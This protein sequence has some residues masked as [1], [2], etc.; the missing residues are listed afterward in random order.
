MYI[1]NGRFY[2]EEPNILKYSKKIVVSESD[3]MLSFYKKETLNKEIIYTFSINYHN[4]PVSPDDF[5]F[6]KLLDKK[7]MERN[8]NAAIKKDKYFKIK[9]LKAKEVVISF[10]IEKWVSDAIKPLRISR[11]QG[12][13]TYYI[14]SNN[15]LPDLV[16]E[17]IDPLDVLKINAIL[18]SKL[19]SSDYY[20]KRFRGSFP[21]ELIFKEHKTLKFINIDYDVYNNRF[22]INIRNDIFQ[23]LYFSTKRG[24]IIDRLF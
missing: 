23:M 19:S 24:W 15:K 16:K 5:I 13:G 11:R 21:K 3:F 8:I 6:D 4:M 9:S 17:N 20:I 12:V 2:R 1:Y 22:N 7:V 18:E 14:T 10:D